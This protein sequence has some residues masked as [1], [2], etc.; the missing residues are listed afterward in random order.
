LALLPG[1]RAVPVI[2]FVAQYFTRNVPDSTDILSRFRHTF[3]LSQNEFVLSNTQT[4]TYESR[5]L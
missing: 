2:G 3:D 5:H 4:T 1:A